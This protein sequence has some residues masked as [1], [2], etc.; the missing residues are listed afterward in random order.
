MLTLPTQ[1]SESRLFE[2]QTACSPDVVAPAL[3]GQPRSPEAALIADASGI[4]NAPHSRGMTPVETRHHLPAARTRARVDATLPSKQRAQETPGAQ[5][6]PAAS[7]AKWEKHTSKVTT[8]RPMQS[9]ASC[10][11]VLTGYF[12]LSPAIGLCCH[13]HPWELASQEL[14]ASVETS[15][16]HDF[17]VRLK[18]AF[19]VRTQSVHRIPRSTSVTTRTS[20]W[21]RRDVRK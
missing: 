5:A 21:S 12:A 4:L 15:G 1:S 16:P 18:S 9:G 3:T 20:L 8:G 13:R 7:R 2:C 19:V 17:A 14:D 6:A 10:A 11:M